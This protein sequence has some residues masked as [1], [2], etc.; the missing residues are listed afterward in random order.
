MI[1]VSYLKRVILRWAKQ[2]NIVLSESSV[3]DLAN[4]IADISTR[5]QC[6]G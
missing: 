6:N 1:D 2:R 3:D 5:E 4:I